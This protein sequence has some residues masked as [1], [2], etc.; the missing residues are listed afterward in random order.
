MN[1]FRI[2][3]N[4]IPGFVIAAV[5]VGILAPVKTLHAMD[6]RKVVSDKGIVAWFVPDTSVPL[7]AMSFA[8]RNAGSATDPD[9]KEGL[10]AMSSALLD[11]GAGELKSQAFQRA[12]EEIAAQMSFSAGRDTFTGALRTLTAE[13]AKAFDLL[14]LALNAPRFDD[15]PVKRIQSQML[16][17]LRQQSKTRERFPAAYGQKRCF[18]D[19]PIQNRPAGLRK[20]SQH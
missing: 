2:V 12:L 11:E 10:A 1:I 9:G 5:A 3:P 4:L 20:P 8:F 18:R 7:V 19:T 14:R 13:R 17:S 15:V 6:I 16:A